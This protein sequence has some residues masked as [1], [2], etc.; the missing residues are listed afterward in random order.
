[1][2]EAI[3]KEVSVMFTSL[4]LSGRI[5]QTPKF[6]TPTFDPNFPDPRFIWLS[7]KSPVFFYE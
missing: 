1:M 4:L 6:E 5:V 2:I 7:E 3:E